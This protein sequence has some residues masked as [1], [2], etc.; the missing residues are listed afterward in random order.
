MFCDAYQ[1]QFHGDYSLWVNQRCKT[2]ILDN[3]NATRHSLD[4]VDFAK[5]IFDNI[6]ITVAS[7]AFYAFFFDETRLADFQQLRIEQLTRQQQEQLIRRRLALSDTA[8]VP[9]DGLVDRA[10]DH[11]NSVIIS[12]KVVPRF[13]FFVLSIWQTYEAYM[14]SNMSI[15]SYGHCYYVLI[16]ID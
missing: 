5:D 13:P 10:E 6:I 15:T 14:P 8:H 7:D 16:V 12:D 4:F 2:L 11:V 1:D 3:L 9:T